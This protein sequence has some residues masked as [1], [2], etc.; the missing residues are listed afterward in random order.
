MINSRTPAFGG[1]SLALRGSG[2]VGAAF[3]A[4]VGAPTVPIW[5]TAAFGGGE[6][7]RYRQNLGRRGR[8][9]RGVG[10]AYAAFGSDKKM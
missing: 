1:I 3:G 9:S 10:L 7:T 5:E 4:P 6:R 2:A 8:P